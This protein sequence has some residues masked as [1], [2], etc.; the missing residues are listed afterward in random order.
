MCTMNIKC[1]EGIFL[2]THAFLQLSKLI[3][4][5]VYFKEITQITHCKF[6]ALKGILYVTLQ[7]IKRKVLQ[8][9][10]VNNNT[11]RPTFQLASNNNC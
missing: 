3:E 10:L 1:F 6:G 8:L 7:L 2:K 9:Q 5:R 11:W 4:V